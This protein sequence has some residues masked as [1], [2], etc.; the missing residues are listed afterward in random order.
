L[1]VKPRLGTV[2]LAALTGIALTALYRELETNGRVSE[3]ST[4][5]GK[6]VVCSHR[7]GVQAEAPSL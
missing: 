6:R 3:Y 1:H 5:G 2:P 7:G 4:K